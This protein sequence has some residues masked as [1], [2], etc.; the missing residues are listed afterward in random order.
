[1]AAKLLTLREGELF[2]KLICAEW[3]LNEDRSFE[4]VAQKVANELSFDIDEDDFAEMCEV[5]SGQ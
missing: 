4:D 3:K 2:R 5:I 1:M